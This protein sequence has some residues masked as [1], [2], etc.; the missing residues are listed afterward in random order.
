[1]V[2]AAELLTEESE[3]VVMLRDG[4]SR[5]LETSE[6]LGHIIRGEG[7]RQAGR[8]VLEVLDALGIVQ[9]GD[10]RGVVNVDLSSLLEVIVPGLQALAGSG[11]LEARTARLEGPQEGQWL[12]LE[13]HSAAP[14][15]AR[16]EQLSVPLSGGS[17]PLETVRAVRHAHDQGMRIL[18]QSDLIVIHLPITDA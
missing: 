12:L 1:V 11:P 7:L 14:I 17:V 6:I 13:M 15:T 9:R 3:T 16:P 18:V 4:L 5:I 2:V 8:P 10:V